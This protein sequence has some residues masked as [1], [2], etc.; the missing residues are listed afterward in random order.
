MTIMN[1]WSVIISNINLCW[2]KNSQIPTFKA[3][4][5]I[6]NEHLKKLIKIDIL[7]IMSISIKEK[8][9]SG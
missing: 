2:K 5:H 3:M 1:Y 9:N 4:Y 8:N 6:C 7:K